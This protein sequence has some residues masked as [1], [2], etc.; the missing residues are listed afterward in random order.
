MEITEVRIKLHNRASDRL[1]AYC[2]ITF[3]DVFVVR[4]VKIVDGTNGLFVAMP[5]RKLAVP[6]PKCRYS[7][8]LRARFCSGCGVRLSPRDAPTESDGRP[9]LHQDVAH[10]IAGSFR[11]LLQS[12]VLEAYRTESEL[13]GLPEEAPDAVSAQADVDGE[14]AGD[15]YDRP[16]TPEAFEEL[17]PVHQDV[18]D[19]EP[20]PERERERERE[21]EAEDTSNDYASLIAGL[22]GGRGSRPTES[23]PAEESGSGR[24]RPGGGRKRRPGRG[25][26]R[27]GSPPPDGTAGNGTVSE[28]VTAPAAEVAVEESGFSTDAGAGR[29]RP[30]GRFGQPDVEA[31][32]RG[33]SASQGED[34]LAEVDSEPKRPDDSREDASDFGAGIL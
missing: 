5:S 25:R 32:P 7:N 18:A 29:D 27:S 33:R 23:R 14:A 1:K 28:P 24:T 4:E 20:E 13:V 12:R 22:Q 31:K 34:L 19:P 16:Q 11:E 26:K 17:E 21:P 10:P 8:P 15:S 6:C 30:T 2:T 3:D 9:R